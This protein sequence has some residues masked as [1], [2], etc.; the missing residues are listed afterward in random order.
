MNPYKRFVLFFQLDLSTK[1]RCSVWTQAGINVSLYILELWIIWLYKGVWVDNG[2]ELLGVS[3]L[4]L[5]HDQYLQYLVRLGG[6]SPHSKI[7]LHSDSSWLCPNILF[8][9]IDFVRC[10]CCDL[11]IQ[12][13]TSALQSFRLHKQQRKGTN[14]LSND[15]WKVFLTGIIFIASLESNFG[16]F[17]WLKRS[18]CGFVLFIQHNQICF[19]NYLLQTFQPLSFIGRIFLFE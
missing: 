3:S 10:F 7:P 4:V 1:K 17:N 15:F 11:T 18:I 6:C 9:V 5:L 12:P 13:K 14:C 2:A 16:I 19:A 8:A